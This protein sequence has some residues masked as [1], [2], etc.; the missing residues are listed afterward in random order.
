MKNMKLK[1]VKNDNINNNPPQRIDSLG[2]FFNFEHKFT[3]S[4]KLFPN[5][6]PRYIYLNLSISI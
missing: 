4:Y 3:K 6:L 2:D 1:A 5:F